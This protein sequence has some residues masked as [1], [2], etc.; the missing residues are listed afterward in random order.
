MACPV[1]LVRDHWTRQRDARSSLQSRARTYRQVG[2]IIRPSSTMFFASVL[3]ISLSFDIKLPN[4]QSSRHPDANR[5]IDTIRE[6]LHQAIQIYEQTPLDTQIDSEARKAL[7][8]IETGSSQFITLLHSLSSSFVSVIQLHT[9][10]FVWC[11]QPMKS[12]IIR[13]FPYVILIP[14]RPEEYLFFAF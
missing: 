5:F 3:S 13:I 14:R 6:R 2:T 1:D 12:A 7:N 10:I 4:G 11:L 8:F 9:H